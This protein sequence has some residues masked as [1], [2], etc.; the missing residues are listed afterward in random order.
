MDNIDNKYNDNSI[1]NDNLN[2]FNSENSTKYYEFSSE[3]ENEEEC[4]SLKNQKLISTISNVLE[5]IVDKYKYNKVD[6]EKF[7]LIK[8]FYS[9]DI[10]EISIKDIYQEY[11]FIQNVK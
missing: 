3:N 10:P 11:Y 9:Y 5:N 1:I 6:N 4:L 2:S 7:P 8:T